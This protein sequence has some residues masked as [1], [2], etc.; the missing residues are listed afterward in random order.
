MQQYAQIIVD[1]TSEKL[2]RTFTYRIPEAL[3][4]QITPGVQVLFPFGNGNRQQKGFVLD[5]TDQPSYDP[6][7]IKALTGI[8]PGAVPV[9]GELIALAAWIR[10]TY[11]STMI[12]ALKTVLPVRAQVK[13]QEEVTVT[14]SSDRQAVQAYYDLCL[15]RKYR[16]R[17]RV[18][19]F[20]LERG[21]CTM[22]ALTG[23]EKSDGKT[24]RELEEKGLVTLS[25]KTLYRN[26]ESAVSEQYREK[27]LT[28]EQQ[29]AVDTVWDDYRR[30]IRQTYL[31]HGV[32][33]SGK[34]EVYLELIEKVVAEGRQVI[35][36]IPE[37]ALTYQ[38]LLRFYTRFGDRV[39]V[40]NSRLSQGE[41][42]DQFERAKRGEIDIM[43]GPRSA[44][45]TPFSRLGF[46]IIDE[47]HEGTYKSENMPRYHAREVAIR[48]AQMCH[49]SVLLGS[50]TPSVES[51]DKAKTG[52]YRLLTLTRRAGN[53]PLPQV[54]ITDMREE[55]REGNRSVFGRHL[56]EQIEDRLAKQE[57]VMLFLNRRGYSGFVSCRSCGAVMKCPHCDVSLSVH[58]KGGAARLVCHYCGYETAQVSR[59]PVC[60][61]GYI[62]EM[63]AGTQQI[64]ELTRKTF[65]GARVLRMDMDTTKN[66][67]GHAKILTEFAEHR[68]DI[69]IGTQMIVKGHDFRDVTLV[70][71]LAAD[72]SLFAGDYRSAERTFQLL[73]QAAGRAG[74]GER[75][76]EMVIQTYQPD[77]YSITLA[78][79]QD[80]EGF[81]AQEMLFRR[82]MSYPP[83]AQMMA[84]LLSC[85]EEEHLAVGAS[86]LKQMIE[87]LGGSHGVQVIGPADASVARVKDRYRKNIY[88]KH[89]DGA[90]LSRIREALEKYIEANEGFSSI[91]IQF[92]FNP[93]NPF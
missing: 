58:R 11:G 81:Y 29:Q 62:S 76:G 41:R 34:T 51:Y 9:E 5:I 32:T 26:P 77:H 12:Q 92:D 28:A 79:A 52:E 7:K 40:I 73:T 87:R 91:A 48:R 35:V 54:T 43:I 80:Y 16:A 19:S 64:E 25:R 50:A 78:A 15:R 82:M 66:K 33:G 67:D 1:I 37:I 45:F 8:V 31:L 36:L 72:L 93:M 83:G 74:R 90:L 18:L 39:S 4:G 59:C 24:V 85:E 69:L 14:L 84:V 56:K 23:R 21:S 89:A 70:G 17:A 22:Q 30:D 44:L 57:Q 61:S 20:L 47:E 3:A 63:K 68:A 49:A 46:I 13:N 65:P 10:Q 42:Y 6:A 75:P 38:T 60:G 53:Q 88:L 86:Y 71:A 2:D 27:V 55:L